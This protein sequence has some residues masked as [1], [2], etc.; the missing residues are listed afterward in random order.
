MLSHLAIECA[1]QCQNVGIHEFMYFNSVIVYLLGV[2]LR[3]L[4]KHLNEG[5]IKTLA[6]N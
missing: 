4:H 5:R 2:L 1:L 3:E 6:W